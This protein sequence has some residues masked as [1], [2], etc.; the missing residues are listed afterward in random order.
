MNGIVDVTIT[1]RVTQMTFQTVGPR[2]LFQTSTPLLKP[3]SLAGNRSPS[4]SFASPSRSQRPA[5]GAPLTF[6]PLCLQIHGHLQSVYFPP[7]PLLL[8]RKESPTSP[9][10]LPLFCFFRD[11]SYPLS[12]LMDGGQGQKEDLVGWQF[13]T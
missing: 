12:P 11:L 6:P 4:L 8:L 3:S 10:R 9:D 1:Q 13:L 2:L 7:L 5:H